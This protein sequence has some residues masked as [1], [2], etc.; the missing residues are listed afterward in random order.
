MA[1]ASADPG[2]AFLN[3]SALAD[4][5]SAAV[6]SLMPGTYLAHA[7]SSHCRKMTCL[8]FG[9][10]LGSAS[11]TWI[12]VGGCVGGT[13][14]VAFAGAP[15]TAPAPDDDVS[16]LLPQAATTSDTATKDTTNQPDERTTIAS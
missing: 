6:A 10:A 14:T 16:P 9:G 5:P 2:S 12:A 11:L 4:Q 7:G 13:A 1:C 8:P 15:A 3:T